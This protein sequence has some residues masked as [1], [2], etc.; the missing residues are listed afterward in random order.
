[1]KIKWLKGTIAQSIQSCLCLARHRRSHMPYLGQNLDAMGVVR[2]TP[3]SWTSA[4]VRKSIA[5]A[6]AKQQLIPGKIWNSALIY[7][8]EIHTIFIYKPQENF[9][10][11]FADAVLQIDAAMMRWCF[12]GACLDQKVNYVL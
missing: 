10:R 12:S 5:D 4:Q 9:Q 2:A 11:S 8:R 3:K 1:M 6:K 7:L